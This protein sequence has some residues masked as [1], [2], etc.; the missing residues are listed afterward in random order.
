MT[1]DAR[2]A[3]PAAA[4]LA[5][6]LGDD[7]GDWA[8]DFSAWTQAD[9][10]RWRAVLARSASGSHAA[11]ADRACEA[12]L[13]R[14]LEGLARAS[15]RW[16]ECDRE[17][18]D[19]FIG[20]GEARY[21]ALDDVASTFAGD[22]MSAERVVDLSALQLREQSSPIVRLLDSTLHDA[23]QDHAS[24]IHFE[25]VPDGLRIRMR[26]DGVLM[27]VHH[28]PGDGVS[29][30]LVS[31]LKVL[32]EL[33]IGERRLPQDGRFR[34]RTTDR[35]IDFRLSVVP[36]IFGEDAV[37]RVLDRAQL[38]PRGGLR[39]AALGFTPAVADTVRALAQRPHGMLLL[40]GPTGSGKTT[41]LYAALAE[42]NQG[43]D[44]IITIEDPIEYQLAGVVQIPVNDRKGLTFAKG[45]RAILRHDPDRV[46]V[47]EIRDAETA[48]I[49]V[50]AAL[51]GHGVFSSVHAN[52]VFDV[53]GRF[54]HMGLDLYNVMSA[55]NGIV[56]QRLVRQP[57]PRCSGRAV[58][59]DAT[60]RRWGIDGAAG[61]HVATL[62]GCPECR[63]T[64]YRGRVAIAEILTLDDEMRDLVAG[65]APMGQIK[66]TARRRGMLG[67]RDAALQAALRGATTLE[68]VERVTV[69]D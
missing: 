57:C 47:G 20:L 1:A 61:G 24:D 35:E 49:A 40:T 56:A 44:K 29:E 3:A 37:V 21:R 69:V 19:A 45:L 4:D 64:G 15:V 38:A 18:I 23:L 17:A 58:L 5:R 30:Q 68:E 33:D 25:A 10:Q 60:A 8:L 36:S 11:L 59:D 22:A 50:Q 55:L 66:A 62:V 12:P 63:Q 6:W 26:L 16:V 9:A 28:V 41:T 32:A 51:T 46:M 39:L 31:R 48:Q 34:L 67:L 52:H 42:T 2:L 14:R 7:A 43:T 27:D 65:R 53:I 54:A 13:R